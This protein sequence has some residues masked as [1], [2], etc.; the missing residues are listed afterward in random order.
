MFTL[1]PAVTII[2]YA[3]R[4]KYTRMSIIA[5][6]YALPRIAIP[7]SNCCSLSPT[8]PR[9][10]FASSNAARSSYVRLAAPGVVCDVDSC[11]GSEVGCTS[12]PNCGWVNK[13]IGEPQVRDPQPESARL[14]QV[15]LA[16]AQTPIT[17]RLHVRTRLTRPHQRQRHHAHQHVRR[18]NIHGRVQR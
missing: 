4:R 3:S 2:W 6:E 8:M 10:L 5:M 7:R 11:A 9:F 12:H 15:V 1:R 14:N 18:S 13:V 16:T 17:A